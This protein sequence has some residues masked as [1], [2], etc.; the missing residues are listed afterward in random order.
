MGIVLTWGAMITQVSI[1]V[2]AGQ[3]G[4]PAYCLSI[5]GVYRRREL[6]YGFCGKEKEKKNEDDVRWCVWVGKSVR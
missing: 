1:F 3:C 4:I 5:I 6:A 2:V